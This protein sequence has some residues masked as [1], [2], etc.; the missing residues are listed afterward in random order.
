MQ[1]IRPAVHTICMGQVR[2]PSTE[3]QQVYGNSLGLDV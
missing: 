1:Y 2:A 3:V